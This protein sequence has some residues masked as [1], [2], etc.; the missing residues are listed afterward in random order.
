MAKDKKS[1]GKKTDFRW[2][3]F[4]VRGPEMLV[5]GDMVLRRTRKPARKDDEHKYGFPKDQDV[6]YTY[7]N[8]LSTD[9][10]A[11]LKAFV[12]YPDGSV[13]TRDWNTLRNQEAPVPLC[14]YRRLPPM[15]AKD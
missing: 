14:I 9:D 1:K 15:P 8:R 3:V 11:M 12:R 6:L 13:G 2:D 5:P 4:M 7:L 10:D